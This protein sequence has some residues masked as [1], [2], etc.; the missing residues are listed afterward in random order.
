MI[1]M[2][3]TATKP[4][5]TSHTTSNS[6]TAT[7]KTTT[8]TTT[9]TTTTTI[10]VVVVVVVGV[11]EVKEEEVD[12]DKSATDLKRKVVYSRNSEFESSFYTKDVDQI[13][14]IHIWEELVKTPLDD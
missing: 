10:I 2:S 6:T 3:R 8:T 9:A 1:Y 12:M 4:T 7:P 11:A 14:T 13:K 5:C